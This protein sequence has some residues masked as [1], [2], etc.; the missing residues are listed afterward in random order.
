MG[1]LGLLGAVTRGELGPD[2]HVGRFLVS[3]GKSEM[4]R[5]DSDEGRPFRDAQTFELS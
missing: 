3:C 2:S 4:G 5:M 1:S